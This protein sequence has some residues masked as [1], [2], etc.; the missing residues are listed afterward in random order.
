MKS[1]GENRHGDNACIDATPESRNKFEAAR[2]KQQGSLA[3]GGVGRER[4]GDVSRAHFQ[5]RVR[6]AGFFGFAVGEVTECDARAV[7]L[8]PYTKKFI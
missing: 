1:R 6:N 8:R 2:V 4:G 5:V 7:L 3:R